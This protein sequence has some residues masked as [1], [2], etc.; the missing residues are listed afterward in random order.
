MGS[1][2]LS[3]RER[4]VLVLGGDVGHHDLGV[5]PPSAVGV[6]GLDLS[7][8]S[9]LLSGKAVE[10]GVRGPKFG[11]CD[12]RFVGDALAEVNEALLLCL[13]QAVDT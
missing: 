10:E 6:V 4:V 12:D 5:F 7:G 3:I 9:I 8:T 13:R 2:E 1:L 11:L